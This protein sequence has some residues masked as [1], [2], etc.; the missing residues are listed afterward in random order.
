MAF[1][2]YILRC[3]D[4]SYYTGHTESLDAR[5]AQHERGTF[6]D[7]YTYVRRPVTLVWSQDFGSRHEA[8]EAERRIKGWSRAKKEAL[9]AGDWDGVSLMARNWQG[10]GGPSTSSGR[11]E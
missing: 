10:G 8:L 1:Y 6:P 5:L 7:C 9:I 3:S 4:G 11:T 2:C